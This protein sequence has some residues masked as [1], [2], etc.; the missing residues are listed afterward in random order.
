MRD[1]F[2]DLSSRQLRAVL[3]V[4]EYRSFV[5]AAASLKAS[6][7][8]LTRTI[9]QV[10]AKLG[11]LLFTR[12]TRE[13]AITD[14]G[15]E[16][17]A[18]AEKLLND[19]KIG[20]ESIRERASEQRGQVIVASVLSLANI[21]V[22]NLIADFAKRF[23]GVEIHLREG[24]QG[25]VRDAVRS[26][27]ADFGV[28]YIEQLSRLFVTQ[29]LGSDRFRIVLSAKH[30]LAASRE[31]RL[32]AL[33]D[34]PLI[35]LPPESRTRQLVDRAAAAAGVP[36]YYAATANRLPTIF[37]LVRN[38]IGATVLAAAECPPA[39]E[40]NLVSRPIV[41]PRISAEIG[42]IRLRE[43]ALATAAANLLAVVRE[44]LGGKVAACSGG[45]N[46]Q[47]R[48]PAYREPRHA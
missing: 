10:E 16:F 3:A 24:L 48:N 43:R 35:S 25:S 22:P 46:S 6:Q 36:L 23:G 32:R 19:L 14:A 28:G 27:V 37:G 31:I 4:A 45:R 33:K 15:K 9:K 40:R 18:L 42:I 34:V 20:V 47:R 11:V 2:P 30:P 5:A 38:G 1:A 39:G 17:A 13:V 26:G 29:S 41:D 21:V 44:G 8:A 7:H 12:S